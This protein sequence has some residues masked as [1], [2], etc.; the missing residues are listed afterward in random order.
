MAE[1]GDELMSGYQSG[2]SVDPRDLHVQFEV[3][4][5][6]IT[7]YRNDIRIYPQGGIIIREGDQEQ[8]LYLLRAGTVEVFKGEGASRE[9]MGRIE[10][11]NIF[12]E[13]SMINDEPRSATVTAATDHVLVYRIATPN[14]HTILTNPMWGELLISR[15]CKNLARCIEQRVAA[16]EQVKELSAEL[17]RLKT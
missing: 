13:M 16:S 7:Y 1:S 14:I 10:A 15:L 9:P 8:A 4:L 2:E 6:E 3:P 5:E 12:G 11:V 17:A